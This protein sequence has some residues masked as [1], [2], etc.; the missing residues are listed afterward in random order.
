MFTNHTYKDSL[1]HG[2]ADIPQEDQDIFEEEDI[3]LLE[4]DVTRSVVDS[5]ISVNFS[6]KVQKL[7]EKSFN[8]TV[9]IKLLGRQ[10][11]Y[12]TLHNKIWK[13]NRD[14]KLMD[15]DND[16]YLASF[17]E[18]SDFLHVITEGPWTIFGHYL[19]V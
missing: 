2:Y 17:K 9:V 15:I 14:F 19:T 18:N 16:Y 7:T 3:E 11:G 6:E 12:T 13:P 8:L 4:G 5:L 10:I 1:L